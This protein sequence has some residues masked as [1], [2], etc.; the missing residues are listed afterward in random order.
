MSTGFF[1]NISL[2]REAAC[3]AVPHGRA[4]LH[5]PEETVLEGFVSNPSRLPA[6]LFVPATSRL[7]GWRADSRPV[8]WPASIARQHAPPG[9][10]HTASAQQ[11][12]RGACQGLTAANLCEP[13]RRTPRRTLCTSLS[14][15]QNGLYFPR[16]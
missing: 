6:G 3:E 15:T 14:R 10:H 12:P 5:K 11:T 2:S 4:C 8:V 1:F 16:A 9:S 7:E 13:D